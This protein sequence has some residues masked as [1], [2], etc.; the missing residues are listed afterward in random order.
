MVHQ[1]SSKSAIKSYGE[2]MRGW[3]AN[4][5]VGVTV[6]MPGY[7][8]SDM[9]DGMPGPKPF[10]LSPERAADLICKAVANNKARVSFPFPLNLGTWFLGILPPAV[11]LWIL[12]RLHYSHE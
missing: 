12:R 1:K 5:G 2:A 10:L 9:C 11:S 6:V 3:L 7:I 4:C 8:K